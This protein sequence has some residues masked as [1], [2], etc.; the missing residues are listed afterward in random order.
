M[1]YL[2][3]ACCVQGVMPSAGSIIDTDNYTGLVHF[4]ISTKNSL[5]PVQHTQVGYG[6][7]LVLWFTTQASVE[8]RWGKAVLVLADVAVVAGLLT[9]SRN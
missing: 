4:R 6:F 7:H 9:N 1:K 5:G 8:H 2:L 3:S